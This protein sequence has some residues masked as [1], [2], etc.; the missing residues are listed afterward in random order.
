MAD[1]ISPE[2]LQT[3][4]AAHDA[5]SSWGTTAGRMAGEV[6]S[7]MA[8]HG[9]ARV[10][11][12]GCGKGVLAEALP[13]MVTN[14]DPA[15]YPERPAP[16]DLVVCI[17]VLEHIEPAALE[18][19][20]DD[21]QALTR[22]ALFLLIS[23]RPAVAVL[24]DGRNAHLIVRPAEWWVEHVQRRWRITRHAATASELKVWCENASR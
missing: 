15:T 11:D 14:Y 18:A 20:L 23:T 5:D 9:A 8:Q 12:Y 2:Y 6:R 16:H 7:L 19:V 4:R 13:G 24:P 1:L 22:R 10:L 3:L 21:L 17:D